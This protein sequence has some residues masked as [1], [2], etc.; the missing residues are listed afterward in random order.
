MS[1]R[2]CSDYIHGALVGAMAG[3]TF[4]DLKW[5]DY[6]REAVAV[7]ANEWA[8]AHGVERR[9]TVADV[10]RIEGMAVGHID[11]AQK[12]PLYIAEYLLKDAPDA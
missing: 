12:L 6:E 4:R 7:A 9:V 3:R 10:E 2:S 11:Y 1:V 8:G 5:I